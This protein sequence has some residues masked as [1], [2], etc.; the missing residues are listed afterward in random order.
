MRDE[1][2]YLFIETIKIDEVKH[3]IP[4]SHMRLQRPKFVLHGQT[5][6]SV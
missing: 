2:F 3:T 5:V 4:R 6:L 1:F